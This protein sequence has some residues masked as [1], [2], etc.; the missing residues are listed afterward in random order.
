MEKNNVVEEHVRKL[1]ICAE[2]ELKLFKGAREKHKNYMLR[3][4]HANNY[5]SLE[6]WAACTLSDLK[7]KFKAPLWEQICELAYWVNREED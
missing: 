6:D 5:R 2:G 7:S 4:D 1:Q 3:V